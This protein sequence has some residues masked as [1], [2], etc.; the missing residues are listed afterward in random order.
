VTGYVASSQCLVP[1]N[2]CF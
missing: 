2:M 1:Q